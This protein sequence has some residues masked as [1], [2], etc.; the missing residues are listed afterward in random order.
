M[1]LF[2]SVEIRCFALAAT[3]LAMSGGGCSFLDGHETVEITIPVDLSGAVVVVGVEGIPSSNEVLVDSTGL[4]QLS[5][6]LFRR[7]FNYE[8]IR[9][10]DDITSDV[11]S[12]AA[13]GLINTGKPHA[14]QL[15]YFV[16]FSAPSE[17]IDSVGSRAGNWTGTNFGIDSMVK[18][19]IR[20]GRLKTGPRQ[21]IS[22]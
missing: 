9:G 10:G 3:M 6:D 12:S 13:T 7:G 16:S 5:M 19:F 18:L 22:F 14:E 15:V 4:G 2:K 20:Q 17:G 21:P 8:V 11:S 1:I